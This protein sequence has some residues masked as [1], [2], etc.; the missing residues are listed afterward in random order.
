MGRENE[1]RRGRRRWMH[2]GRR[3]RKDRPVKFGKNPFSF[4]QIVD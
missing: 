1:R 3:D 2:R 4:K